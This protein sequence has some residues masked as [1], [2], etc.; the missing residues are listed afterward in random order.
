MLAAAAIQRSC[1]VAA[2][3]RRALFS[4]YLPRITP[5]R[6]GEAGAGGRASNAGVKVAVFGAGGFLGRY[7]ACELGK[8]TNR[9]NLL[10][11]VHP[12]IFLTQ[13]GVI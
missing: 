5:R 10:C 1:S 7:V 13:L 2:L 4:T 6:E 3:G 9:A 12:F 8:R 11:L